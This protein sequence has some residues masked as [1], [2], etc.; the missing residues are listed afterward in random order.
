M[1]VGEIFA[2]LGCGCDGP[3]GVPWG[4]RGI[5]RSRKDTVRL[6]YAMSLAPLL[7]PESAA[8]PSLEVGYDN[9]VLPHPTFLV[10]DV[11]NVSPRSLRDANILLRSPDATYVYPGYLEDVPAG[12][13]T[14][15]VVSRTDAEECTITLDHLNPGQVVKARFRLD[16]MPSSEPTVA[17]PMPD[18]EVSRVEPSELSLSR[19]LLDLAADSVLS[20]GIGGFGVT[21]RR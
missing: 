5:A 3:S 11:E 7:P 17:C 2:A 12:Y 16:E 4:G 20:V 6:Q 19:N 15:W 13:E 8:L 9:D 10:L 1:T 18:V 14:L 21:L